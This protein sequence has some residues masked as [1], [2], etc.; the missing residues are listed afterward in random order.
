MRG[1]LDVGLPEAVR[2]VVGGLAD[3]PGVDVAEELDPVDAEDLGRL[4]RLG[5]AAQAELLALGSRTPSA[6]LAVLAPRARSPARRG[7]PRP[8]AWAMVPPV[9]MDSSSGW[10]W[11]QTSVVM[12]SPYRRSQRRPVRRHCGRRRR[13]GDGAGGAQLGDPLAVERR[14]TRPR[15]SSVCWPACDG[16][17][18]IS[19]GRAA[20]PRRRR[21]LGD[22]RRPR[23]RSAAATLWG[24]S[25]ASSMVSTGAKQTSVPSMISHHSSRVLALEDRRRAGPSAPATATCPCWCGSSSPVRDPGRGASSS[26]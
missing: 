20:E 15:I 7:G 23:R 3:H 16:G 13:S 9:A 22:A 24:C 19:A 1:L 6:D 26:A 18:W 10:A 25:G 8:S 12:A 17:R 2:E 5:D 14:A 21:R 4:E 11:K